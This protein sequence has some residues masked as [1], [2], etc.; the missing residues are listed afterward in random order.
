[1]TNEMT[2]KPLNELSVQ[3]RDE[4]MRIAQSV[5]VVQP[6]SVSQFGREVGTHTA[7]YADQLLAQA[8]SSD[9]DVGGQ[10]LAEVINIAKRFNMGA[11]SP[12]RSRIPVIGGLLDKVKLRTSS[13]LSSFDS[14]R[15]QIETLVSEV[16]TSQAAI[17][18]RVAD[19][20]AMFNAVRQEHHAL[21][22]HVSAAHVVLE[23]MREQ[24]KVWE[25]DPSKGHE[26]ADLYTAIANLD[27]RAGDLQ[28][29]QYS[30]Y[31]C[32]PMIRMIQA[33]HQSLLDK[34]DAIRQ[35]TVP[36]WKQQFMLALTLNEQRNA[37]QLATAIDDTTN[38]LMRSNANLLHQ[39]S[40][41]TARAGQRMVID[42]ETL[43]EV[44]DMLI[45]TAEDVLR[46][47]DEGEVQRGQM[48]KKL[49]AMQ[50]KLNQ[51]LNRREVA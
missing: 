43:Q 1:M 15:G 18:T 11:L 12:A 34:M 35:V 22:L 7:G 41:A 14:A 50:L 48:E 31:Q 45:K 19:L 42:V 36:A 47:R 29:L 25:S 30:A 28:A 44:N 24:A 40:V 46:V 21:G 26:L 3:D 16:D 20:D 6:L 5:D 10:K 37:V 27:K 33:N 4:V 2:V 49:T 9:L 32:L 13:V 17:R 38:A 8:R 23:R 39:N 51:Q